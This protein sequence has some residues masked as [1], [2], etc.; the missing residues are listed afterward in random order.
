MGNRMI[1]ESIC[2]SEKIA[3]LT[4]F[5]FRL[6]VGLI[7]Q[8]DDAGRG[9][10]RPAVIKGRVFP[11]RERITAKDV[12]AALHGLAAKGCVSLYKVG[13]KPYFWFPTWA[14]HQR[15]REVKPKFPGPEDADCDSPPQAAAD[16]GSSPQA[17]ADCGQ[18]PNQ[19]ETNIESETKRKA[20]AGASSVFRAFSGGDG[21][22][23]Q[24]LLDFDEMRRKS[25]KPMTDKARELMLTDLTRLSRDRDIQIAILNQSVKRGWLGVFPLKADPDR[26]AGGASLDLAAFEQSI[27]G[28]GLTG[29]AGSE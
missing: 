12:D 2:T 29:G 15:I 3:E 20:R 21:E 6:W 14:E 19:T 16:C 7:T 27:D 11:L 25:R 22:L 28:K 4:D 23:L 9:D 8:A 18:K 26:P 5:E 13:G 1:K 24:A 17:A 10:A